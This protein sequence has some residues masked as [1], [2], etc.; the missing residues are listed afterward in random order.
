MSRMRSLGQKLAIGYAEALLCSMIFLIFFYLL[1]LLRCRCLVRQ[2]IKERRYRVRI[3]TG[4]EMAERERE[5]ER[6]GQLSLIH[7]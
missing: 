1:L 7:I 2:C 4:E 5:R 6:G 3:V